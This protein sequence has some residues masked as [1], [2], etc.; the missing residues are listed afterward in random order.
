MTENKKHISPIE[1][2]NK[3]HLTHK[4]PKR[5]QKDNL[6][7]I[8]SGV[9]LILLIISIFTSTK[10]SGEELNTQ[11]AGNKAVSFI[12][13]NLMQPGTSAK[14]VD[15]VDE[16]NLYKIKLDVGGR[17]FESYL[18]KDGNMLFPSAIDLTEEIKKEE[19]PAAAAPSGVEKS[20][21]P[22]AELFIMSYC[23]YGT[24]AEK[25]FIPVMELLGDKADM[26]IR[27][28]HYVMHGEEED[29]ENKRE[30][31]IR[32]E[33]PERFLGY[34]VCFLDAGDIEGCTAKV[35]ID[36]DKLDE[37]METKAGRYNDA[38]SALSQGYGVKGSPTL[39]LNG[40]QTG[41]GRSPA[42]YLSTICSAFNEPPEECDEKVSSQTP[43][44]GF[45]YSEYDGNAIASCS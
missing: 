28:V 10:G 21:K 15:V 35:N 8:I 25:G 9:L 13:D 30:M 19:E 14:I 42:A 23:P 44:P 4:H 12:N 17:E 33:Q 20:D 36:T 32:E 22:K 6:W 5:A 37:C 11:D 7:K 26:K 16:N 29:T 31:C 18:T 34:M 40:V 39:I 38:D 24:Q 43:S 2:E 1:E 45:G 27:F 3:E 41:S